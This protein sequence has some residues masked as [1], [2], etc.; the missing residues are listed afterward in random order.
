MDLEALNKHR[1]AISTSTLSAKAKE[2]LYKACDKKE[3]LLLSTADALAQ[4]GDI[5]DIIQGEL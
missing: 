1:V 2:L 3:E 5:S 4:N